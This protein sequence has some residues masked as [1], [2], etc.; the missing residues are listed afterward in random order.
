MTTFHVTTTLLVRAADVIIQALTAGMVKRRDHP[1][2]GTTQRSLL[3][4]ARY[5]CL[6]IEI[7]VILH[8]G[9]AAFLLAFVAILVVSTSLP[10]VGFV[11]FEIWTAAVHRLVAHP[12]AAVSRTTHCTQG[13]L[14]IP[15]ASV[16]LGALKQLWVRAALFHTHL[17]PV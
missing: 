12:V 2:L 16:F 17:W 8:V 1:R 3:A 14:R 9:G 6:A 7:G 5:G 4:W 13:T 11:Q 10:G 15:L